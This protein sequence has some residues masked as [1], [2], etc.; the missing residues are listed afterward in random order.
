[1]SFYDRSGIALAIAALSCVYGVA[2]GGA[3]ATTPRGAGGG[4]PDTT[5]GVG[6]TFEVR[7]YGEESLTGTYQVS[8]DGMIDF[9][10]VGRVEVVGR[11][12]TGVAGEIQTRLRDGG[13]LRNP[14]VRVLVSAYSSKQ[15]S[16]MGAV[17]KPGVF[18]LTNGIT[19]VH[20][21]S[22]A[23]GLSSVASGNDVIVSRR[24]N[25]ELQRFRVPVDDVSEGRA[26]DFPLQAGDIIF[27]PQRVF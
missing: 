15:V 6:D 21:I 3:G 14:Q 2:C 4:A 16:V 7:V 24:V 17:G 22:L 9:P 12:P 20:A 8:G 5:L 25:G 10:F 23:G 18:P 11:E 27:V 19:V 1:M 13:Y 26:D